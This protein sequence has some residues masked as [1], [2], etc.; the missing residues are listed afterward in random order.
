MTFNKKTF[1]LLSAA[2]AIASSS[3]VDQQ[4]GV[5]PGPGLRYATDAYPGFDNIDEA[6]K[7][8]KKTPRWFSWMN[9]PKKDNSA[10][11]FEWCRQCESAGSWRAARRG[12]DAL[13]R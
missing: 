5:S 3:A 7:P 11:Q 13:V 2:L 10:D 4:A 9:G 6:F 8:E 12:Y 1:A